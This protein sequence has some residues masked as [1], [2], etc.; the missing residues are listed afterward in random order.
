MHVLNQFRRASRLSVILCVMACSKPEPKPNVAP[1]PPVVAEN[2]VETT[3][4]SQAANWELT[5]DDSFN[6]LLDEGRWR[7]EWPCQNGDL[8]CFFNGRYEAVYLAPNVT[9]TD[10]NVVI[11]TKRQA[12]TNWDK[13]EYAFSSGVVTTAGGRFAQR[14]GYYEVRMK[15]ASTPGND[16]AFWLAALNGWPPEVDIA[17]IP[18]AYGG[19][20]CGQSLHAGPNDVAKSEGTLRATDIGISNF[21]DAYHTYGLLWERGKLVWFV[22]GK[23]TRRITNNPNVPDEPLF[24]LL[25]DE[26]RRDNGEWFGNPDAGTY[27]ARTLVD[28]VRVWKKKP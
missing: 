17:E 13:K 1:P 2:D 24:V 15:P 12:Y 22:D 5:L 20:Q 23:E 4:E 14:Y 25:S 6:T 26:I 11:E 16:P 8:T 27:P 19:K 18:G 28:W 21:N 7:R 9:V 3:P 10:S